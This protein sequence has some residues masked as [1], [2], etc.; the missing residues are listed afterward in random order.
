MQI[1]KIVWEGLEKVGFQH[2]AKALECATKYVGVMSQ[3]ALFITG[4][5]SGGN[6]ER[7]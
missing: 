3:N 4:P 2:F 7:Q 6:S 1:G 5:P